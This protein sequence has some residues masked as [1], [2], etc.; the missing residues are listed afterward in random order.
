MTPESID[1][2]GL[3]RESY[4]IDGI[5]IAQCRSIFLD[6]VLKLPQ[7]TDVTAAVQLM[8]QTHATD[9][10]EH[11]MSMVLRDALV[12]ADAGGRRG[13]ASGRRRR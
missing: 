3:I 5:D 8:L 12:V 10:M 1:K 6:W 9:A 13:G 4:R 7:D 2:T 11:P